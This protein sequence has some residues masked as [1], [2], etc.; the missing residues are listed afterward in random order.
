MST[1]SISLVN[2]NTGLLY[3]QVVLGSIY[4]YKTGIVL[5]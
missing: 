2:N 4:Y 5:T 1:A 3:N